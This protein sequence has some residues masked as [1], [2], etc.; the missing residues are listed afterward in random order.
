MVQKKGDGKRMNHMSVVGW[1]VGVHVG[2]K[3]KTIF[4]ANLGC[5]A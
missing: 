4:S 1:E 2:N 3:E 5:E